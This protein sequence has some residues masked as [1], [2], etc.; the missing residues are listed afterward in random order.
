MTRE[1]HDWSNEGGGEKEGEPRMDMEV[2]E[3]DR[4]EEGYP[5]PLE[6]GE[7]GRRSKPG[8]WR[9]AFIELSRAVAVSGA[10]SRAMDRLSSLVM[11]HG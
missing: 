4:E 3:G 6:G 11:W 9:A 8:V 1:R 5:G 10:G 2:E 7:W